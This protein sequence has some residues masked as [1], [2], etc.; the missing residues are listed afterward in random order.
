MKKAFIITTLLVVALFLSVALVQ[1]K[2]DNNTDSDLPEVSGIYNVPGHPELK[3]RVH[4]YPVK[5]VA[6][7]RPAPGTT[8]VPLQVCKLL[9]PESDAIVDPAGWHLKLGDWKYRINTSSVPA[10]VGKSNL[11]TITSRAFIEWQSKTDL[12]DKVSFVYG[13][14]TTVTRAKYDRQNI[15]TW[16]TA[17]A[18]ALAVT[19]TWYYV[20]DKTVAETDTIFNQKFPWSWTDQTAYQNCADANSYDAQDVLT[21]E[22]GHWAGLNDEYSPDYIN[23][24]MYGYGAKSEVKADTL[25]AGDI[26]GINKI[27]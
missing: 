6:K 21:H 2:P 12:K 1:A 26:A 5:D 22:L 23:N 24:T 11:A 14:T 20:S 8:V 4:V 17:P 27:Y 25:T 18:S 9:D 13:G 3:V 19:Y 10:S 16:G 15:V 7:A